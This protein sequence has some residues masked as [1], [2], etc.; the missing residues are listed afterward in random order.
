MYV[1]EFISALGMTVPVISG[2]TVAVFAFF[3][4]L[5]WRRMLYEE[6]ILAATFA[7]YEAYARRTARLIPRV[8]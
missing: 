8:W 4:I 1:G 2:A 5:Q 3:V 6:Y 7:D